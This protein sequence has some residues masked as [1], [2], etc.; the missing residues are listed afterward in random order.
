MSF[1]KFLREMFYYR[2]WYSMFFG[3]SPKRIHSNAI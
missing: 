1:W 2:F 3:D